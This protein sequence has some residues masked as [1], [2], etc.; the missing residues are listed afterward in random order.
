MEV[1]AALAISGL[2]LFGLWTL[3][4]QLADARD[5][6]VAEANAQDTAANGARLLRALVANTEASTDTSER[7]IGGPTG[8][9]FLTW[10]ATPGGWLE[11]CRVQLNL[12]PFGDSS[13]L[14]A[15]VAA[16]RAYVVWRGVGTASLLYAAFTSDSVW[17]G[18][19]GQSVTIPA[20]LAIATRAD[21]IVLGTGA[22]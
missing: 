10:C 4:R 13:A 6:I 20:A 17:T 21:T 14:T 22:R 7:F 9:A 12:V 15:V 16:Q 2:L 1:T 5:R 3:L 18:S 11:H 19:W 8:A